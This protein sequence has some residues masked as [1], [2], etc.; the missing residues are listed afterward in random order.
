MFSY[1]VPNCASIVQ[2]MSIELEAGYPVKRIHLPTLKRK[3]RYFGL[4]C[5]KSSSKCFLNEARDK[6]SCSFHDVS[7]DAC[8]NGCLRL[9]VEFLGAAGKR[10]MP[11]TKLWCLL[12]L[13]PF[14][15]IFSIH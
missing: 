9:T 6:D 5:Y 15:L 2:R 13:C 7:E 14:N 10:Q 8:P 12:R 4:F 11:E 3:S 1:R